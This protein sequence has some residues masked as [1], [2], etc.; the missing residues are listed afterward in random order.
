M[1]WIFLALKPITKSAR[2]VKTTEHASETSPKVELDLRNLKFAKAESSKSTW[3]ILSTLK[4][5]LVLILKL[6]YT[7]RRVNRW[8]K[9]D[10]SR[11][12]W[13]L[14]YWIA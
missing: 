8:T 9:S 13:M 14:C 1:R 6:S 10:S 4:K 7:I 11:C 12:F 5:N 3:K 2:A